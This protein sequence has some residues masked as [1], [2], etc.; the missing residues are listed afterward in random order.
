M[1]NITFDTV[2][3][4]WCK[5][6]QPVGRMLAE[7]TAHGPGGEP[8]SYFLG[9]AIGFASPEDKIAYF[10]WLAD[11]LPPGR[12]IPEQERLD[13]RL[14]E[15]M[16]SDPERVRAIYALHVEV[17]QWTVRELVKAVIKDDWFRVVHPG[18][19]YGYETALSKAAKS[20]EESMLALIGTFPLAQFEEP[21]L[22]EPLKRMLNSGPGFEHQYRE[23][24]GKPPKPSEGLTSPRNLLLFALCC[25]P[26]LLREQ[27]TSTNP[28]GMTA[29]Q[30]MDILQQQRGVDFGSLF[31]GGVDSFAAFARRRFGDFRPK[32][33]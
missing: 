21:R 7:L 15:V 30:I 29:Q 4:E 11:H 23:V 17:M 25:S 9:Q 28:M 2:L 18:L 10:E 1:S 14:E 27:R 3:D 32:Q 19:G 20:D 6:L 31:P 22:F 24:I 16:D 33:S 26:D 5:K 12:E 13:K 8:L